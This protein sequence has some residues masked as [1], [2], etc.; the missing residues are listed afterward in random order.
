MSDQAQFTAAEQAELA[1]LRE[2]LAVLEV[3]QIEIRNLAMEVFNFMY[4]RGI[5]KWVDAQAVLTAAASIYE[6]L[7]IAKVKDLQE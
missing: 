1:A 2:R 7:A 5:R 6:E 3:R 4:R